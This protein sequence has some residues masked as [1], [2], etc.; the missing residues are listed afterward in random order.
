MPGRG[1]A[2]KVERTREADNKIR[3]AQTIKVSADGVLRGFVL[4]KEIDWHPRTKVWWASWRTSP[5]AQTFTSNDW[6]FLLDTALLHNEMWNGSTN[7]AAEI[8]L[9]VSAFGSTPES[10]LRLRIKITD[11]AAEIATTVSMDAERRKRLQLLSE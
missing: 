9:R 11:D 7:L 1:P 6:D 5:I 3:E 10:R 4:P 8:R 2:P